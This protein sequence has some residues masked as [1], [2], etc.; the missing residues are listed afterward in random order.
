MIHV[1]RHREHRENADHGYDRHQF[2]HGEAAM[3]DR[4]CDNAWSR[5]RSVAGIF[6]AL[7]LAAILTPRV[8]VVPVRAR[9]QLSLRPRQFSDAPG[10]RLSKNSCIMN[11]SN[12]LSSGRA[13]STTTRLSR[14]ESQLKSLFQSRG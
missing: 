8:A 7:G 10:V 1:R 3:R 11:S 14:Y 13:E 4:H 5:L 9:G 6:R 12:M 2:Q